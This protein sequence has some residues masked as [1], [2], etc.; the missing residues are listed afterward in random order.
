MTKSYKLRKNT[1]WLTHSE[2]P[3]HPLEDIHEE[4]VSHQTSSARLFPCF[5]GSTIPS[6]NKTSI[7]GSYRLDHS[8]LILDISFVQFQKGKIWK[9]NYSLLTEKDYLETMSNKIDKVE[10]QYALPVYNIGQI[11]NI[12]DYLL[13]LPL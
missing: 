13:S 11:N 8:M 7:E 1:V 10:K 6:V 5:T 2:R 12:P 3:T 4:K 9:H